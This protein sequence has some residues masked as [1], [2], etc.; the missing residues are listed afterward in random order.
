M[1]NNQKIS[2]DTI[3]AQ[4][5]V[6]PIAHPPDLFGRFLLHPRPPAFFFEITGDLG[7]A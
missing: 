3:Q 5:P 7:V 2:I 1:N 4:T 6:R